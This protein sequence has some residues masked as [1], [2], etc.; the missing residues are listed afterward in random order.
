MDT[1]KIQWQKPFGTAYSST[2]KKDIPGDMNFGGVMTTKSGLVFASGTRDMKARILDI[3]SGTELWSD[4]LPAAGSTYP[5]TFFID[6]CQHI[7]FTATGGKYTG[8]NKSSDTIVA[9]KLK[10]CGQEK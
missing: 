8:F 1:G 9:Y 4:K 5:S 6:G 10:T 7:V 3:N 2:L